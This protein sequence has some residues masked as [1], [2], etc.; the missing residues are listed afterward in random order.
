VQIN[1]GLAGIMGDNVENCSD[2]GPR[3]NPGAE[4]RSLSPRGC[5][6]VP[7]SQPGWM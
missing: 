5:W 7:T 6:F 1:R 2:Y 4:Q 3:A